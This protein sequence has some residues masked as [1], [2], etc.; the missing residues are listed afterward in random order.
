MVEIAHASIS[1]TGT[2]NGVSGDQTGKEVCKR[3]WYSKPWDCVIRFK[4]ST[5][6]DMVALCMEKAA[7]NDNIGYS[8]KDRNT[9]FN[10]CRA[11]GYDVSKVT[12][13]CNCDCSSLVSVA[14]MYAGI[15]EKLLYIYGNCA[16]TRTL[17]AS[18]QRTGEVEIFTTADYTTKSDKLKRGDILLSEGHHVAVVI[19]AEAA[20]TKKA[21]PEIVKQIL[22]GKLGNGSERKNKVIQMGYNYDDVQRKVNEVVNMA[23]TI[24]HMKNQ[25]GAFWDIAVLLEMR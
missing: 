18:L 13:K 8:Q 14:C 11:F 10:E 19:V 21:D 4:S 15:D 20:G 6:A 9:L 2:V 25:L 17:K 7:A 22:D 16:T 23:E 1:E 5:M 24:H 12:K 3:S